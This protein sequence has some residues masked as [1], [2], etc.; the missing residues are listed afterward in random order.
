M[1][2]PTRTTV[3]FAQLNLCAYTFEH[4]EYHLIQSSLSWVLQ[5]KELFNP[6][7]ATNKQANSTEDTPQFTLSP[8]VYTLHVEC[9]LGSK[10]IENVV[11]HPGAI[12]DEVVYF[13]KMGMDDQEEQFDLSEDENFDLASE[14]LRRHDEREGQRNFADIGDALRDPDITPPAEPGHEFDQSVEERSQFKSHPI[15]SKAKQFDGVAAN[16]NRDTSRS[17]HAAETQLQPDLAPGAT[18]TQSPSAPTPSP[19]H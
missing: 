12:I 17:Q 14:F 19:F 7:I 15:L 4:G 9:D 2:R 8:G 1:T 18:P 5:P 11:L 3:D 6:S 10:T 16:Q 13:G